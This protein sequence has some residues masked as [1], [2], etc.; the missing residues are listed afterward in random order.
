M[1]TK[2]KPRKKLL[3]NLDKKLFNRIS[4]YCLAKGFVRNKFLERI[5][6]EKFNEEVRKN[7]I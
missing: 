6:E 7:G 1:R 2:E 4:G 5:I 3:L